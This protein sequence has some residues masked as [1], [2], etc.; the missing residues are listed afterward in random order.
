MKS[1]MD[2]ETLYMRRHKNT[3]ADSIETHPGMDHGLN[4]SD[5]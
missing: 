5:R 2:R 1:N 3:K 4:T